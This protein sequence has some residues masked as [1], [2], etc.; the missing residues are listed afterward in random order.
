MKQH[1]ETDPNVSLLKI[2]V[3]LDVLTDT[4]LKVLPEELSKK[5]ICRMGAPFLN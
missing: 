2:S 4:V 1:V 5:D 3:D